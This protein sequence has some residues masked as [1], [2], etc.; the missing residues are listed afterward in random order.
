A[1]PRLEHFARCGREE[2][3]ERPHTRPQR[4]APPDL[5][6]VLRHRDL[7][8]VAAERERTVAEAVPLVD[9]P[10]FLDGRE[11]EVCAMRQ[12]P[13][14]RRA[15]EQRDGGECVSPFHRATVR[16]SA[17]AAVATVAGF[18]G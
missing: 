2:V 3:D 6:L 13:V 17:C 4:T 15:R 7:H 5:I 8:H 18:S 9:R 10:Y 12:N 14:A 11:R 16:A 1:L